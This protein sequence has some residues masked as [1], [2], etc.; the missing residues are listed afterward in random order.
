MS[1]IWTPTE[2]M[3]WQETNKENADIIYKGISYVLQQKWIDISGKIDWRD[4]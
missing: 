1:D 2:E 3:R 4:V